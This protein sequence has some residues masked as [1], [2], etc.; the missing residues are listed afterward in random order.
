VLLSVA[1]LVAAGAALALAFT[2][3]GWGWGVPAALVG[4]VIAGPAWDRTR[5]DRLPHLL[6]WAAIGAGL[7]ALG[8]HLLV[9]LETLPFRPRT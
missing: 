8:V 6:A 5:D 3:V 1:A 2:P 4:L 9:Y 7:I